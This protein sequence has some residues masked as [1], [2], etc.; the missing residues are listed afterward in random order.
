MFVFL[1]IMVAIVSDVLLAERRDPE[2]NL[3]GGDGT[4]FFWNP[5]LLSN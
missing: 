4:S 3:Q 2:K 5:I 1:N